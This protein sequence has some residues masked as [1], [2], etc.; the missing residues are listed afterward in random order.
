[1]PQMPYVIPNDPIK[2]RGHRD[3]EHLRRL[4]PF[5][6]RLK[7]I[8][9]SVNKLIDEERIELPYFRGYETRNYTERV[10][11]SCCTRVLSYID[12]LQL[13][14]EAMRY[15]DCH[16]TTMEVANFYLNVNLFI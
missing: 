2:V 1:M 9:K 12:F 16:K 4:F 13:I 3:Q 15:G 6:M 8:A 5:Q 10:F 7:E 14:A 11:T